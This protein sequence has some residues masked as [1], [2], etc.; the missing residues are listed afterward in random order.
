MPL[1]IISVCIKMTLL[2]QWPC[3]PDHPRSHGGVPIRWPRQLDD[4]CECPLLVPFAIIP[5]TRDTHWVYLI[6]RYL[7]VLV[8]G[9]SLTSL[10]HTQGKLVKGMGGAMD[11]VSSPGTK[12]VVT[13]EHLDKK[14]GHKIVENCSLPLTGKNC[15]DMIITDKVCLHSLRK[16]SISY[17]SLGYIG[18]DV[19]GVRVARG[20][21]MEGEE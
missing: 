13:M 9:L 11:L 16:F 1:V 8:E 7:L 4:P 17:L 19:V 10:H 20:G 15:V 3:W 14:G 2:S 18:K 5:K 6:V 12:V 21:S